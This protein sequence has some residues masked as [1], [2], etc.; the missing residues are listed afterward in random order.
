MNGRRG[1]VIAI[2]AILALLSLFP[3]FTLMYLRG[4]DYNGAAFVNDNDESV[5]LAYS[6]SLADGRRRK[7]NIYSGGIGE[8][9]ETFLSIQALPAYVSALPASVLGITAQSFFPFLSVLCAAFAALSLFWFFRQATGSDA[10]AAVAALLVLVVG[11]SAAGYGALKYFAGLGHPSAALPFLRRH[12]PGLAFPFLLIFM[13]CVW[14]AYGERPPTRHKNWIIA[15]FSF[16]VLLYSYF[17]LWTT[18]IAWAVLVVLL[19]LVFRVE[20][21]T[22]VWKFWLRVGTACLVA[23]VPYFW[24]LSQRISST[25]TSQLLEAT[26][27]PVLGRPPIWIGIGVI[28]ALSFAKLAGRIRIERREAV[29]IA[30]SALSPLAV[31]NQHV[32]TGHSLQPFHYNLY[33]APY[34]ALIGAALFVWVCIRNAPVRLPRWAPAAIIALAACWGVVETHLVTQYR[35]AANL[36]RDAILPVARTLRGIRLGDVRQA[37]EMVTFNSDLFQADHQPSTAPHGVLWSEHLPWA[38]SISEEAARR[39][40]LIHL[41]YSNKD[42]GWLRRSLGRCPSGA[43]CKAIFG[44]RVIPS[45]AIGTHTPSEAEIETVLA[46]FGRI[47]RETEAAGPPDPVPALAVIRTTDEFDHANLDKWF[48]RSQVAGIGEYVIYRLDRKGSRI[49][50]SEVSP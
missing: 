44:A 1:Y 2:A 23:A 47:T 12:T 20:N 25:D 49:N 37:S 39:R 30:A 8:H 32:F 46:E 7:N 15:G 34:L 11:A 21:R 50:R 3:Q 24:L 29:M 4:P 28:I 38:A 5:Y 14:R 43:E 31:F 18:A 36:R 41:Y 22:A 42:E 45:L 27:T 35:L 48:E 17:Y 9:P 10:F 33:T 19:T 16:A 26:R 13:G 6:Q 40:Y